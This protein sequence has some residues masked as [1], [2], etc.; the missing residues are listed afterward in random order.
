MTVIDIGDYERWIMDY[1]E[2]RVEEKM[3]AVVDIGGSGVRIARFDGKSIVGLQKYNIN[4]I[5]QL[6]DAIRTTTG[7][8]PKRVAISAAGYVDAEKG[9]VRESS[10]APWSEGN[11]ARKLKELLQ[12]EKVFV[13]NDGEA[14]TLSLF[15]NPDIRFGAICIAFG[16]AVAFGVIDSNGKIFRTLSGEN[17]DG[18]SLWLKTRASHPHVWWALGTQGLNELIKDR[19]DAG[20]RQFG[21][22]IGSF[23]VQMTILFRPM[24]IALT[25]GIIQNHWGKMKDAC[26]QDF[27]KDIQAQN[28]SIPTIVKLSDKE[29]ALIGLTKLLK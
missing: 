8:S 9:I 16:T 10:I 24:T 6:A 18:C 4:S 26:H 14:H 11:F 15:G 22:R 3:K 2:Q 21:Y 7:G 25:G 1:G 17:W 19:G 23:L 13:V 20:Y 5:E 12:A 27:I 29:S 28:I